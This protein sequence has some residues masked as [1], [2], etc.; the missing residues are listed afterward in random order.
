MH[1]LT[2]R[3]GGLAYV[4]VFARAQLQTG[5]LNISRSILRNKE[6]KP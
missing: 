4:R 1:A 5:G 3:Q 2:Y 6:T